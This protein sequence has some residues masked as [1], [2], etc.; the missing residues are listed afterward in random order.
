[1]NTP[2]NVLALERITKPFL[3]YCDSMCNVLQGHQV[4]KPL[5]LMAGYTAFWENVNSRQSVSLVSKWHCHYILVISECGRTSVNGTLVVY[6]RDM[7]P[8]SLM[9]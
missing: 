2:K 6:C 8:M 5:T 9:R 4:E 1:M 3:E 7:P